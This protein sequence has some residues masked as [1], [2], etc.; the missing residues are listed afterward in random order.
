[1]TPTIK[2]VLLG[3]AGFGLFSIAD[4]TIKFL[5]GSYHPVQIVAFASGF[6][7]PLIAGS[8]DISTLLTVLVI[9]A[10]YIWL[11]GDKPVK[12]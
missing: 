1:M 10:I 8:G 12:A 3:L 2:G 11:R 5:G 4:A 9:P 7:L 6:T